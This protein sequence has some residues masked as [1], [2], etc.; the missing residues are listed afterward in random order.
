MDITKK[1]SSFGTT[2]TAL[3]INEKL[4][5]GGLAKREWMRPNVQR[6]IL[7]K[8]NYSGCL[9]HIKSDKLLLLNKVREKDPRVKVVG[10]LLWR[11]DESTKFE[12][13]N[14]SGPDS[15]LHVNNPSST[16]LY[17]Q[18]YF[19]TYHQTGMLFSTTVD[20]AEQRQT[21]VILYMKNNWIHLHFGTLSTLS[22]E[23]DSELDEGSWHR[24]EVMMTNK[25]IEMKVD[26]N[27][28][29]Y[30]FAQ[31]RILNFSNTLM[32]GKKRNKLPSFVGC[33]LEIN[34]N[35]KLI[36]MSDISSNKLVTFKYCRMKD[37]CFP[38]PCKNK[39][40]CIQTYNKFQCQ[41]KGTGYVGTK[42]DLLA[43]NYKRSC[44]E[45]YRSGYK[46]NGFYHIKPGYTIFQVYCKMNH[47]LGPATIINH[48]HQRST[49]VAEMQDV[50]ASFYYHLIK[51]SNVSMDQLKELIKISDNCRQHISYTCYQSTLMF[52]ENT[53]EA[54]TKRYGVRWYSP[55]GVI[56]SYWGGAAKGSLKCACAYGKACA[57]K[58]LDCNCDSRDSVWRS[59]KGYLR[60]KED[61][62]VTKLQFSKLKTTEAS[63]YE[64]GPLECFG[65]PL[66]P[67][68]FTVT[69]TT[70]EIPSTPKSGLR[71]TA[72]LVKTTSNPISTI[73]PGKRFSFSATLKSP[74]LRHLSTNLHII[75]TTKPGIIRKVTPTPL[76][77]RSISSVHSILH[78][79]CSGGNTKPSEATINYIIPETKIPTSNQGYIPTSDKGTTQVII[80]QGPSTQ[81]KSFDSN[82][83]LI[84]TIIIACVILFAMIIITA[85][86]RRRLFSCRRSGNKV[87]KTKEV[88]AITSAEAEE[89]VSS[90]NNQNNLPEPKQDKSDSD[91]FFYLDNIE[92]ITLTTSFQHRLPFGS[93]ESSVNSSDTSRYL[94][95]D[96]EG[97]NVSLHSLRIKERGLLLST[98]H[99]AVKKKHGKFIVSRPR[100]TGDGLSE[101][102]TPEVI[103]LLHMNKKNK[104]VCRCNTPQSSQSDIDLSK[105]EEHAILYRKRNN[106]S[107]SR[108]TCSNSADSD[109]IQNIEEE[110]GFIT[111]SSASGSRKSFASASSA[112][113]NEEL[114]M[115]S[116]L[117]QGNSQRKHKRSVRFSLT[118]SSTEYEP[119]DKVHNIDVKRMSSAESDDVFMTE[120]Q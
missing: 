63:F 26:S 5:L 55:D 3:R 50:D 72:K 107:S 84:L 103:G 18:F 32:V 64:L 45:Y 104:T 111:D 87:I 115:K 98:P 112:N 15:F 80:L 19:R 102:E 97:D 113:S 49:S 96:G 114:Q 1:S 70:L 71:S 91:T 22:L 69:T 41:C 116:Y 65:K 47:S 31:R 108:S 76:R 13:I 33:M 118:N 74:T 99:G 117:R 10:S 100:S 37:L 36:G 23:G 66:R 68:V 61:L 20:D 29:H 83:L 58:H 89:S 106:S 119:E 48:N 44:E 120:S 42:C 95:I 43:K 86:L 28:V 90:N 2:G 77:P 62:P 73:R 56:Q 12:P 82:Q 24:I 110:A 7:S 93:S 59:D 67:T 46:R 17:V 60:Y 30:Q 34:V 109:T 39:G 40:K 53:F 38:N 105:R 101:E 4:S 85:L 27:T 8:Q 14:F 78:T 54:Q 21:N 75:S 92:A 16:S 25:T 6:S 94:E 35:K 57:N 11:C 51:Y 81:T 88:I 9:Y 79:K 52:S